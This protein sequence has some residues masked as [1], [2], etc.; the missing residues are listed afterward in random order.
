LQPRPL[1]VFLSY[2]RD[3]DD[4]FVRILHAALTSRD[5]NVW[6]DV[7]AMESRGRTFL[8]EIR[9]AIEKAD[10][11]I[12]IASPKALISD[13][14][15]AEVLH[16]ISTFRAITPVVRAAYDD[17]GSAL[18]PLLRCHHAID[19]RSAR[20][21]DSALD[22]LIRVLASSAEAGPLFGVPN[23]PAFYQS[24][25]ELDTVNSHLLM[26]ARATESRPPGKRTFFI[27]G[28]GGA[29]KSTLAAA[30]ANSYEIRFAFHV[31]VLWLTVGRDRSLANLITDLADALR[32]P[33]AGSIRDG[34]SQ[35]EL[36]RLI[37]A[38]NMLIV[39]DDLWSS[40]I[41][42]AFQRALAPQACLLV[43]TRD[44]QLQTGL[45]APGLQL[46]T[47]EAA[48]ARTFLAG[49]VAA[50]PDD[51]PV[52]ALNVLHYCDGLPFAIALC[53]ALVVEGVSWKSLLEA[54]QESDLGY[55][56]TRFPGY[57][58]SNLLRCLQVSVDA[59]DRD[60]PGIGLLWRDLIVFE[61]P[62]GVPGRIV[63]RFWARR[64]LK[65]RDLERALSILERRALLR[66]RYRNEDEWLEFHEL[67]RLFLRGILG[68]RIPS[69][70]NELLGCYEPQGGWDE[71]PDDG[72]IFDALVH[73]LESAGRHSEIHRLVARRWM[74]K[75]VQVASS[76]RPFADDVESS[77]RIAASSEPP[78]FAEAFRSA[79]VR[80]DIA[81]LAD[82]LPAGMFEVMTRA[83]KSAQALAYAR[84]LSRPKERASALVSIAD[85]LCEIGNADLAN[86]TYAEAGWLDADI[87]IAQVQRQLGQI[88]TPVEPPFFEKGTGS[89][90]EGGK[91]IHRA[92]LLYRDG[93]QNEATAIARR[94]ASSEGLSL[95]EYDP[96]N[97]FDSALKLL[98]ELN[99]A[100]GLIKAAEMVRL[101]DD[102]TCKK[103]A[104][105]PLIKALVAVSEY[106]VARSVVD[107]QDFAPYRRS[108]LAELALVLSRAGRH[109]E[110]VTVLDDW[111]S[112]RHWLTD[113]RRQADA[114]FSVARALL[115]VGDRYKAQSVAN[116]AVQLC[117]AMVAETL[118]AYTRA[119]GEKAVA[120]GEASLLMWSL[121]N[122]PEGRKIAEDA[123]NET[124]FDNAF[125][126]M[127][128]VFEMLAAPMARAGFGDDIIQWA[129]S[130]GLEWLYRLVVR[131]VA[132]AWLDVGRRDD[133]ILILIDVARGSRDG[134]M[135]RVLLKVEQ[136][137]L[138]LQNAKGESYGFVSALAVGDVANWYFEHGD[139]EK[140][141]SL[142]DEARI[143]ALE[144][145]DTPYNRCLPLI[146]T[147]EAWGRFG[148]PTKAAELLAEAVDLLP[149]I[150]EPRFQSQAYALLADAWQGI[151]NSLRGTAMAER[152]LSVL[153]LEQDAFE[154]T[155]ALDTLART[156]GANKR[157]AYFNRLV[158]LAAQI[159]EEDQRARALR[160]VAE[161]MQSQE[162]IESLYRVIALTKFFNE[163][164]STAIVI[165]KA[166]QVLWRLGQNK[167]ALRL[168]FSALDTVAKAEH[169][170][171]MYML[172]AGAQMLAE[173]HGANHLYQLHEVVLE[174]HEWWHADS[175]R[176]ETA[177]S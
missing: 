5:I 12:L 83:G 55:L 122:R 103:R 112:E 13:Y 44:G 45:A 47:L 176:N 134:Q 111:Q 74:T 139:S 93:S 141:R 39:L 172:E 6:W 166:S 91:L 68:D 43:T 159:S 157:W 75:R 15:K 77:L 80:A 101:I 164:K 173:A 135:V 89:L 1:K 29:G 151:G 161:N 46:S 97:A 175:R 85:T 158:D 153:S 156:F 32:E 26:E 110:A 78:A 86:Q 104:V 70:H 147:A 17:I 171:I 92:W 81:S 131:V 125:G 152:S 7:T 170:A 36:E 19:F 94:V 27:T 38:R 59:L 102:N 11:F 127:G 61:R 138:A 31:G 128:R 40:D 130:S 73:H 105:S 98:C 30:C 16:A 106:G 69:L 100:E 168:W 60:H 143:I 129:Y 132:E 117:R 119:N 65:S 9:D 41:A 88:A 145:D 20:P 2:A 62:G 18:P 3:D 162:T 154:R 33:N 107:S 49:W 54:L 177:E 71:L 28:M 21:F 24:R 66:T 64:S 53:G 25:A 174:I 120:L 42:F 96:S 163:A 50:Q 167:Q 34:D 67:H 52:E 4:A 118:G 57:P 35:R 51:L 126:E 10:R 82:D 72:Y 115:G 48:V 87:G 84:C 22:E 155:L 146:R 76:Y 14:V 124:R 121:D 169:A 95:N 144:D 23:I 37:F 123:V 140:A 133:A 108:T 63:F 149:K 113:H 136:P 56:A 137:D 8:T 150:K 148:Q 109:A 160:S 58:H 99:D 165:G 116:R 79:L 114:L 90:G 142:L